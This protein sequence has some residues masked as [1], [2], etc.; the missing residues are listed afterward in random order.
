MSLLTSPDMHRR[1]ARP[2]GE[3]A[4]A[5]REETDARYTR[6]ALVGMTAY[7][8]AFWPVFNGKA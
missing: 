3:H 8:E 4:R 6:A 2:A 7:Y 1:W 5:I